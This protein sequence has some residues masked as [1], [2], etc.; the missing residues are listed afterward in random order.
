[1]AAAAVL[2]PTVTKRA[3]SPDSLPDAKR[4]R[5]DFPTDT[6][7]LRLSSTEDAV[8]RDET[9]GRLS[10]IKK[11][12]PPSR[13]KRLPCPYDDCT[14][15]F[16][17]PSLL[18]EHIRSHTG[19]RPFPCLHPGCDSAFQ[20]QWHLDR[21]VKLQHSGSSYTCPHE[22]CG[23]SFDT[24]NQLQPHLTG[25][26]TRKDKHKCTGFP[27]CEETFRKAVTLQRHIDK[28]HLK[29]KPFHCTQICDA[30][31]QPC[32]E[33]FNSKKSL[34]THEQS[35]HEPG[36]QR[37]WCTL[38]P[39]KVNQ[40]GKS[41]ASLSSLQKHVASRHAGP[42]EEEVQ[43][44]NSTPQDDSGGQ[45]P[46]KFACSEPGC[47][48]S[49][50]R[51]RNLLTHVRLVHKNRLECGA[52]DLSRSKGLAN[53]DGE[54]AC[55]KRFI[56]KLGLEKHVRKEH[57]GQPVPKPKLKPRKSPPKR[58][59]AD[60]SLLSKLTGE[61]YVEESGRHISCFMPDCNYRFARL[62]DLEVHLS[63][64]HSMDEDNLA[65][66][67]REAEALNGGKFWV[68]ADDEDP[69]RDSHSNEVYGQDVR[70]LREATETFDD[71]DA[72][73]DE[74][75]SFF[76]RQKLAEDEGAAVD[77]ESEASNAIDPALVHAG[78]RY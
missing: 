12:V 73:D 3:L 16:N 32:D 28:T 36:T 40:T 63:A 74:L 76:A 77:R 57:L 62:Y 34:D 29:R 30:S 38:C 51:K 46:K 22:G 44:H 4:T 70:R 43:K 37:Y 65:E 25:K 45:C 1:M 27:P 67:T 35:V 56:T 47:N 60:S 68:G 50:T 39:T 19:D 26:H 2:S 78:A 69:W 33:S 59:T 66:A 13:Q 6:P 52:F 11:V 31:G 7:A 72:A 5:F 21:H 75:F 24:N 14:R 64:V 15:A 71:V 48:R 23:K 54:N 42:P 55:G 58:K 49:F 18:D 53:W 8:P 61:G 10:K 9:S 20:R 17:R 41:F